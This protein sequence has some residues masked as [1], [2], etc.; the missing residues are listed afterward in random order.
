MKGLSGK[1]KTFCEEY[2]L[3]GNATQ[4]AIKA[5]YSPKLKSAE[6]MGSRLLSND[7]VGKYLE[8]LRKSA[9]DKHTISR[10]MILDELAIIITERTNNPVK[11]RLKA[12]EIANK[13]CGFN[14]PEKHDHTGELDFKIEYVEVGS[15]EDAK[16]EVKNEKRNKN[17]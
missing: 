13:M 17:K 15:R 8:E 11:D 9:G 2:H 3:T 4:S 12:M 6:A 16:K 5:G 10:D 14:E 7:K 1:Q